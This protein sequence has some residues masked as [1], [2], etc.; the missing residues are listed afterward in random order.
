MDLKKTVYYPFVCYADFEASNIVVD[1][2]TIQ[3]PNSYVILSPDLLLLRDR[4]MCRTSY[5]KS[6]Y[7]DNPEE[8]MR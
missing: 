1:G 6:F 2:K 3:V 5:L 8:L 7:S 4:R